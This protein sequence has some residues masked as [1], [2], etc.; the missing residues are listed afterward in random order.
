MVEVALKMKKAVFTCKL[1]L[2]LRNNLLM[3]H[4]WSVVFHGAENS[5]LWKVD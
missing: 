2:N 4:V 5:T 1:D 3:C